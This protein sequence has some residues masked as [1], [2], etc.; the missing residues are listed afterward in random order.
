MISL[1][2][3]VGHEM[4]AVLIKDGEILAGITE[5]R[6]NRQKF[7][8]AYSYQIPVLSIKY[9]LENSGIEITEIDRFIYNSA[10]LPDNYS[11]AFEEIFGIPSERVEY[12][13]HHLAHAF[14]S[15]YSSGFDDAAVLVIDASGSEVGP[16][17]AS[18][19]S[20]YPE[21]AL[22]GEADGRSYSETVSIFTFTPDGWKE[23]YKRWAT[24]SQESSV[25]MQYESAALQLTYN[26]QTNGWQAGKVMGMASY[27][28]PEF[29]KKFPDYVT[30]ENGEAVIPPYRISPEITYKSDFQSKANL[31]GVYQR[32]QERLIMHFVEK[33]KELSKSKNLCVSGGSFLNC[34]SNELIEKSDLF[35]GRYYLPSAT[36]SGIPLGCAWFGQTGSRSGKY[37]VPYLGRKY[38]NS[39]ILGDLFSSGFELHF[40][41]V[42]NW[43]DLYDKVSDYL[44][45]NKV[46]GW[47][48]D[49]CETG[50]RALGNRSILANP[51]APWME[52]YINSEIKG[53]E[54]YRP[55]A[56][57]V[58]LEDQSRIFDLDTFS[59]YMLITTKVKED[60]AKKIPAVV[61]IDG[62]SRYQSVTQGM[63]SKYHSLISKFKQKTGI[64]LLLNTSFN[65]KDEPI[66]ETPSDAIQTFIKSG[67]HVL[68]MN[69]IIV[70]KT[71]T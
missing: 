14:S 58:L 12:I 66:V 27:A 17:D 33:A 20:W 43:E 62:T 71:A 61:H 1:G 23:H 37:L 21:K 50:P 22:E 10:E 54:W 15:F 60:W 46:I 64:P 68:V 19:N 63:N 44:L 30:F 29:L 16:K 24:I 6:L 45:Q 56:P 13:P 49:G 48:Q 39:E 32:E 40:E 53:R 51:C 47:F 25:G 65:G 41:E 5:E 11:K 26:E 42:L 55:F 36:D 18:S 28:D 8:G 3:S 4:G 59:P 7:Y 67:L 69:N 57:S 35:E 2:F 34:N 9:C 52:K 38:S 70:T 31:A